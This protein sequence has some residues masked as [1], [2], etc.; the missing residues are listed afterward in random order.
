MLISLSCCTFD[1]VSLPYPIPPLFRNFSGN[2]PV[3][4]LPWRYVPVPLR[5]IGRL[6]DMYTR[7]LRKDG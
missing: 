1:I 7:S 2:F 4:T 3:R 6:P 5:C